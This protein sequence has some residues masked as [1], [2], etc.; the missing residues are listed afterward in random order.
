MATNI[1]YTSETGLVIT[2]QQMSTLGNYTAVTYVDGFV[3]KIVDFGTGRDGH[4]R[5]VQ[6]YMN[7][8]ENKND[9]IQSFA[10]GKTGLEVYFN[11]LSQNGF[12]Q[13]NWEKYSQDGTLK[14]IGYT[15]YNNNHWE[16]MNL[17]F[18]PI[19]SVMRNR[20][21][22]YYFGNQHKSQYDDLLLVFS[23]N[24]DG[25]LSEITDYND[26]Y[27]FNDGPLLP[28][29]FLLYMQAIGQDFSWD[30]HPYYHTLTPYLP[31]STDL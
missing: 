15:V 12:T 17:L 25:S 18:D 21:A 2:Q 3:K 19:T 23:Y 26:T 6:Y 22:K 7:S 27:G 30:Q 8:S 14:L 29:E 9:V 11:N 1:I 16:I 10:D 20:S 13:W 4:S 28:D 24:A 5:Y 31:N